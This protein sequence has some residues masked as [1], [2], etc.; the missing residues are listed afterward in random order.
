M[1]SLPCMMKCGNKCSAKSKITNDKWMKIRDKCKEWQGLDKFSDIF[2]KVQWENGDNDY[3]IC[4]SCFITLCSPRHLEQAQARNQRSLSVSCDDSLDLPESTS[5]TKPPS[6]KRLRSSIG[7]LYHPKTACV[8]CMKGEDDR[9]PDR[10]TGKLQRI[11][12]TSG[13]RAFKRHTVLIEDKE[14][15][16]RI[17]RVA[18]STSQLLDPFAADI[19]YHPSCWMR[20]V[21][22]PLQR[23]C[24]TG[25]FENVTFFEMK[26]LFLRYI[27]QIIFIDHEIRTTQSLL[28]EY[29][30]L[31]FEYGFTCGEVRGSYIKDMLIREYGELIGFRERKEE[32]KVSLFSI[33]EE[34]AIMWTW[35]YLL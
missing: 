8:W 15:R 25:H 11:E 35:Q 32:K 21:S 7:F 2:E 18:E 12:T 31:A 24:T 17:E 9:H 4:S 33:R 28:L 34:E 19:V 1:A 13:W 16:V 27:D 22:H 20:Y 29:K 14:L 23:P 5:P 30:R 26:N 6:P 3:R 10:K